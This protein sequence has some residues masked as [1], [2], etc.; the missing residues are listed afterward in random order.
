MKMTWTLLCQLLL[1]A[2]L[3]SHLS[4]DENPEMAIKNAVGETL[5]LK[6]LWGDASQ[7]FFARHANDSARFYR[8]GERSSIS[9][10]EVLLFQY[11]LNAAYIMPTSYPS[12]S[13]YEAE[14]GAWRPDCGEIWG[15]WRPRRFSS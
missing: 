4:A 6:V 3:S 11:A 5:E 14:W 13:V 7:D 9:Y 12:F 2:I 10:D 15:V 1:L 8:N